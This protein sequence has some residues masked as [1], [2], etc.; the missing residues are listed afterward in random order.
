VGHPFSGSYKYWGLVL[1]VGGCAWGCKPNPV[2]NIL[3]WIHEKIEAK[4]LR[5]KSFSAKDGGGGGGDDES[6][7]KSNFSLHNFPLI[8]H[9]QQNKWLKIQKDLH[10]LKYL[11]P[12]VYKIVLTEVAM[13]PK[14]NL[15]AE[16]VAFDWRWRWPSVL[17]E[18]QSRLGGWH[19]YKF[20][21]NVHQSSHFMISATLPRPCVWGLTN[22]CT[23][24]FL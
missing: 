8:F 16:P 15:L 18:T 19:H 10:F 12:Y 6:V 3:L 23:T 21:G 1:Q 5:T 22:N 14:Y 2:K 13:Q 9:E 11:S 20:E 17:V 7:H 4:T 24:V